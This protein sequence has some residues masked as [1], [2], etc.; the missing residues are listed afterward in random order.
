MRVPII[1]KLNGLIISAIQC[2]KVVAC[3][4][5]A[6]RMQWF[7]AVLTTR[8]EA[9]VRQLPTSPARLSGST[10]ASSATTRYRINPGGAVVLAFRKSVAVSCGPTA[11]I[12]SHVSSL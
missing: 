6:G 2:R 3:L 5:V 8:A 7:H 9:D 1:K 12:W 10:A 11:C 4:Q